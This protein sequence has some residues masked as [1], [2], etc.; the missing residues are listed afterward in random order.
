MLNKNIVLNTPTQFVYLNDL[1]FIVNCWGNNILYNSKL[2]SNIQNWGTI[3]DFNGAHR[4]LFHKNSRSYYV[5]DT[6]NHRI[7]KLSENFDKQLVLPIEITLNRPH[8]IQIVEDYLY[9]IDLHNEK[10]RLIIYD[11]KNNKNLIVESIG[12]F[13]ARSLYIVDSENIY[14]MASSISNILK[15][16][17]DFD[18]LNINTEFMLELLTESHCSLS[19]TE[20]ALLKNIYHVPNDLHFVNGYYYM[21]NYF[22]KGCKNR[23]IRFVSFNDLQENIFEDLSY[24]VTGVPYY[25]ESVKNKLFI[26]EID[27]YSCVKMINTDTL[28][29]EIEINNH[30]AKLN[31]D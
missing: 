20:Q 24:L 29:T 8:D 2:D 18:S 11:L 31:L 26:T 28:T 17:V 9:I 19:S 10:C 15:V 22:Y 16:S 25:F 12:E 23:L 30:N 13:Y 27:N 1:Y 14:V 4:I 3:E 5:A 21:S 7:V 6:D